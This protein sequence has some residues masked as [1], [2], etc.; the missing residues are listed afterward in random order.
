MKSPE[1]ASSNQES[2]GNPIWANFSPYPD[3]SNLPE[4]SPNKTTPLLYDA[5]LKGIAEDNPDDIHLRLDSLNDFDMFIRNTRFSA[6]ALPELFQSLD[7]IESNEHNPPLFQLAIEKLHRAIE[8]DYGYRSKKDV[9]VGEY[10]I[11]DIARQDQ[12]RQEY[13]TLPDDP[14]RYDCIIQIAPDVAGVLNPNHEIVSW[15]YKHGIKKDINDFLLDENN[16]QK[17]A[18]L[19]YAHNVRFRPIIDEK[20]SIPLS[21]ISLESQIHLID[22]MSK[23]DNKR[24]SSLCSSLQKIETKEL[25][26]K[27]LE[28]FVATDFGDDFGDSLLEIADSERF[29]DE[30]IKEILDSFESCRKS[31]QG[32][33]DFYRNFDGGNF[34][35]EYARAAN[36]RLT[37]ALMVFQKIAGT[38]VAGADLDWLGRTEF[39]YE[40]AIEAL[41]Y[42]QKSLE[43]IAGTI[44]D[45]ASG[46][47]GA[48]AEII[49]SPIKDRTKR[50]MYSLYSPDH[51]YCLLYTRPEGAGAFD[52]TFEYGNRNGVEASISFI[53]DPVS[54][55]STPNPFRPQKGS[56]ASSKQNKVSAIRL[57]REGRAPGQAANDP[58]RDPINSVGMISVDLAAVGDAENTP[59]GKIARLFSVGNKIRSEKFNRDDFELNHN[60]AWFEQEKYGTSEGFKSL[61]DYIDSIMSSLCKKYPPEQ[62]E[63]FISRARREQGM[64]NSAA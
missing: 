23:S 34:A 30:Q 4:E 21:D 28:N 38:G 41:R 62:G 58:N 29:S 61:V 39:D 14:Y 15:Q 43:I 13:P 45:I 51:G 44:T 32:I 24:F 11:H 48:S 18:L 12:L 19:R 33:T 37:D 64:E 56:Y 17:I 55:F 7:R 54:P 9:S 35:K 26:L 57:D 27:L 3:T 10:F 50:T 5:L 49:I 16:I 6:D 63:D 2:Q 20:L 46:K 52:S 22:F 40:T 25:K 42:E 59:S 47:D 31:I 8:V 60:T 53:V 36:E 1:N